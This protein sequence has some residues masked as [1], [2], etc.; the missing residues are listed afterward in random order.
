MKIRG[1]NLR[2]QAAGSVIDHEKMQ[3]MLLLYLA[4]EDTSVSC[5]SFRMKIDRKKTSVK[6]EF[7]DKKYS[8]NVFDKR[9]VKTGTETACTVPYGIK[10]YLFQDCD[11]RVCFS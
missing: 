11:T 2:T 9:V 7:F 8:N 4:G 1:F 5:P 3:E 6:N 10:H